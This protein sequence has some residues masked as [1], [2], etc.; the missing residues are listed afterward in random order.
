MAASAPRLRLRR[1]AGTAS[2]RL[3]E[4]WHMRTPQQLSQRRRPRQSGVPG[5]QN[6]GPGR[7]QR[8]T[9]VEWRPRCAAR[10]SQR[11]ECM[12]RRHSHRGDSRDPSPPA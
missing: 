1:V 5:S 11:R 7:P 2:V 4:I 12:D 10:S 9:T 8:G 6:A 3:V